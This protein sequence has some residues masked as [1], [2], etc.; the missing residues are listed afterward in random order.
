[1][2]ALVYVTAIVGMVAIVA[3]VF[4]RWLWFRAG[5]GGPEITVQP[6]EPRLKCAQEE[7]RE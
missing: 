7:S 3:I 4:K 2:D 6:A 1:M 5:P